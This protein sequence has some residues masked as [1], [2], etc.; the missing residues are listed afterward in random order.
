M[1]C[2]LSRS[3]FVGISTRANP[4]AGLCGFERRDAGVGMIQAAKSPELVTGQLGT[5]QADALAD[6]KGCAGFHIEE[7]GQMIRRLARTGV[8]LAAVGLAAGCAPVTFAPAGLQLG[9]SL[10]SWDSLSQCSGLSAS[11]EARRMGLRTPAIQAFAL[12]KLTNQMQ[13]RFSSG[14][15]AQG[16]LE[17]WK[18]V[19]SG[20]C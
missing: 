1:L 12:R 11:P 2:E 4:L 5:L 20:E 3:C 6:D 8:A 19:A 15:S 7:E 18:N 17:S 9:G 13:A 10:G 14:F 16:Q